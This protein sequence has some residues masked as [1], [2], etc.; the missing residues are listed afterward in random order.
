[1]SVDKFDVQEVANCKSM[2]EVKQLNKANGGKWFDK[3]AMRFFNSSLQRKAPYGGCIFVTSERYSRSA[4]L[5]YTIRVI[6]ADGIIRT[7]GDFNSFLS[8]DKAHRYAK[9]MSENIIEDLP[10]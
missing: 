10:F 9:W 6:Q 3:G 2:L 4:A 8:Y 7:Y 5:Q 1:M